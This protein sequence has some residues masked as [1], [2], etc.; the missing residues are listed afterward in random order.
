MDAKIDARDIDLHQ[1]AQGLPNLRILI[2][3][4]ERLRDLNEGTLISL[5]VMILKAFAGGAF[6]GR[7]HKAGRA[8]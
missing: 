3:T 5:N 8:I 1:R 4:K 6:I 7:S 2:N